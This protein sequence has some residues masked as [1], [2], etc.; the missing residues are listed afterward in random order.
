[1]SNLA[2]EINN[3]KSDNTISADEIEQSQTMQVKSIAEELEHATEKLVR[4]PQFVKVN[5]ES[6]NTDLRE[7]MLKPIVIVVI[8]LL[9][10]SLFYAY[11]DGFGFAKGFYYACVIGFS[12]GKYYIPFNHV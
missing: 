3:L 2:F 9:V 4:N 7:L 1:M 6:S 11:R 5:S 8:W 12:I 10:G